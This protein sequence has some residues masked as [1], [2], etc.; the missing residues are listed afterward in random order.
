[1]SAVQIIGT[2][3]SAPVVQRQFYRAV[4][5][6]Y[7]LAGMWAGD[8]AA[9]AASLLYAALR[10]GSIDYLTPINTPAP[11][12]GANVVTIDLQTFTPSQSITV[13]DLA[14][15]LDGLILSASLYSLQLV[16][17]SDAIGGASDTSRD[18][19]TQAA[20]ATVSTTSFFGQL[21]DQARWVVVGLLVLVAIM[22]ALAAH[23][24]I[25]EL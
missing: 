22:I 7:P 6:S 25:R 12:P 1:M 9:R 23:R 5:T 14:S 2:T 21:G 8:N 10:S 3:P 11:V 16:K 13:A 4:F 20:A 24:V 19:A 17:Q 15:A 18:A